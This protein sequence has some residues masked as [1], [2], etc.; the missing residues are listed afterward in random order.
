MAGRGFIRRLPAHSADS[1]LATGMR[2]GEK[3]L[4][5]F[6][7]ILPPTFSRCITAA[8]GLA[9]HR[10]PSDH[11]VARAAVPL[12][13]SY[14]RHYLPLFLRD[15]G[16][17]LIRDLVISRATARRGRC[18]ARTPDI[19]TAIRRC[20]TRDQFDAYWSGAEG[21]AASRWHKPMLARLARWDA[22]TAQRVHRFVANSA[23]VAG[24][25]ADTIIGWRRLSILRST[26]RN[27]ADI[28]PG[29]HF[30]IV[31]PRAA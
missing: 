27:P 8:V 30:L 23:H 20:A 3:V 15:Q 7:V 13:C 11:D 1:R 26:S 18:A 5:S 28:T 31:G 29:S 25:I 14:Y 9:G 21:R 19:S 10:A 22:A 24:R 17:D 4:G 16:F 6:A 2:G 12:A